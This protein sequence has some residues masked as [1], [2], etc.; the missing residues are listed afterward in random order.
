MTPSRV[1]MNL[2]YL[3]PGGVGGTETYARELIAELARQRPETEFV[4]YCGHEAAAALPDPSWPDNVTVRPLRFNA[5]NR[6]RR[7]LT[8]LFVL[9]RVAKREGVELLHSLGQTTPL[10]GSVPRVVTIHDLIFHHFPSTFSTP[11][12]KA[13]EFLVPRG[14][15]RAQRV[16][17]D[18]QATADDLTKTYGI[19]AGKIDVAPIGPGFA[20]SH[21]ALTRAEL[22]D[23]LGIGSEPFALSVASGHE[24]KNLDRLITAFAAVPGERQLIVV[25]RAGGQEVALRA[26]ADELGV[27]DRVTFT[28][29][30]SEPAL[31]GLYSKA[32]LFVYPT[33]IEGFGLP[34]L[35]AMLRGVP[36][37]CSNASSLPEVAGD[38]AEMFDPMDTAAITSALEKLFDD[39]ARRAE[40]I[41]LGRAQA[42]KFSWARAAELTLASY[43]AATRRSG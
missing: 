21:E 13:H 8:E 33:L 40:L 6:P 23:Q 10:R 42:A 34:V 3:I 16:I 39:P 27:G 2:L 17:T 12:Q 26:Q 19:D 9:P 7:L 4:A 22:S 18:S 43:D 1:G 31:E 5:E 37:A 24:H 25:G 28:G 32:E 15:R 41:E 35:E 30:I 38:A 11:A 36:V 20:P 29:W 14:A